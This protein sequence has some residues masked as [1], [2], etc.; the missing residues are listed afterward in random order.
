MRKSPGV[1]S[2]LVL[3]CGLATCAEE[4][5]S[6]PDEERRRPKDAGI[7]AVDA[8]SMPPPQTGTVSCYTEGAPGNTCALPAAHCCFSNYSAQHD[9]ACT[10]S[11]CAYGTIA[12]D[13]PEDCA[14][15]D[16]CCSHAMID[17]DNGLV[18]YALACHAGACGAA[19]IDYEL[20]HPGGPPCSNGGSCVTAYGNDNDLPRTLYIC[21]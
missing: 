21:R 5:G 7:T 4:Q 3:L 16:R 13:G 6:P 2:L 11:S 17:P 10:A 19:P 14:T 1:A 12:C 18:G 15:G 8:F 9:G 20:C